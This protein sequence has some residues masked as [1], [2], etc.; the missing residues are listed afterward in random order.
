MFQRN[1]NTYSACTNFK[2]KSSSRHYRAVHYSVNISFIVDFLFD[3]PPLRRTYASLSLD[4]QSQSTL[5]IHD[6]SAPSVPSP[7]PALQPKVGKPIV[8]LPST[9]SRFRSSL[10]SPRPHQ[11]SLHRRPSHLDRQIFPHFKP[12]LN[13]YRQVLRC[14]FKRATK[15]AT[16]NNMETPTTRHND[17][18]MMING[19]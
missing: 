17:A 10:L 3:M 11:S 16:M 7:T 6:T 5:N 4:T 9:S 18:L 13:L 1:F 15:K 19:R 12:G 14:E 2:G 8:K